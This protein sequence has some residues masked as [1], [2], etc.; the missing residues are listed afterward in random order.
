M[1]VPLSHRKE[2]NSG[3]PVRS[4]EML[5]LR[6]SRS[7]KS[8][9]CS[10]I[11][12]TYNSCPSLLSE[13]SLLKDR[14]VHGTSAQARLLQLML[15]ECAKLSQRVGDNFTAERLDLGRQLCS[16]YQRSGELAVEMQSSVASGL[17]QGEWLS[18]FSQCSLDAGVVVCRPIRVVG[19][20]QAVITQACSLH[21]QV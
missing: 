12:A 9:A 21:D 4:A 6:L 5:E 19:F 15:N 3:W 20:A 8:L 2:A 1:I 17:V 18:L 16:L 14:S 13:S 10:T 11:D 7:S